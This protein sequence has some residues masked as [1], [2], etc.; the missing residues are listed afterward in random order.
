MLLV[1]VALFG[2]IAVWGVIGYLVGDCWWCVGAQALGL[3]GIVALVTAW[4]KK[5]R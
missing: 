3:V 2:W 1:W 5:G 4:M